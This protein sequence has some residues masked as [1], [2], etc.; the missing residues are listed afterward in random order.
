MMVLYALLGL[1]LSLVEFIMF[2]RAKIIINKLR[3]SK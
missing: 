2:P 1:Y 3:K